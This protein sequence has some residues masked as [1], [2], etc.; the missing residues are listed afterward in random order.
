VEKVNPRQ[1]V[2]QQIRRKYPDMPLKQRQRKVNALLYI[3]KSLQ[4]ITRIK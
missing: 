4:L 3:A 2:M 1:K